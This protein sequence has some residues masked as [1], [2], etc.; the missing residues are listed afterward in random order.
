MTFLHPPLPRTSFCRSGSDLSQARCLEQQRNTLSVRNRFSF[1]LFRFS[2][3]FPS[4]AT[5][6]VP[7]FFFSGHNARLS[8]GDFAVQMIYHLSSYQSYTVTHHVIND[9][10]VACSGFRKGVAR[11][12][13]CEL[14]YSP[15][16]KAWITI[17]QRVNGYRFRFFCRGP[18]ACVL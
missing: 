16:S 12:F 5:C 14:Y 4:V 17:T 13:W 3:W 10:P 11:F 6:A 9:P 1:V 8:L 15:S 2:P 7:F 18:Q